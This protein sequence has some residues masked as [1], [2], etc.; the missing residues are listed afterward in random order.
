MHQWT[1]EKEE[2]GQCVNNV[3]GVIPKQIG[4]QNCQ[5]ERHGQPEFGAEEG[6]ALRGVHVPVSE[7]KGDIV[8]SRNFSGSDLN[9]RS[10]LFNPIGGCFALTHVN[11]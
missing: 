9:G 3:P 6:A 8:Q 5:R 2:V 1:G 4:A 11:K 10:T 7:F